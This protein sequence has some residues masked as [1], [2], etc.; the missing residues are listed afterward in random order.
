MI[1]TSAHY[2]VLYYMDLGFYMPYHW[3]IHSIVCSMKYY[4]QFQAED[5]TCKMSYTTCKVDL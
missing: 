4:L 5:F 1:L 3:H 2:E